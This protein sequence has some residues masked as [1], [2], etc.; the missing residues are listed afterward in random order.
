MCF[1][2]LYV[3]CNC[4]KF[5]H[6]SK[7]VTAFREGGLFAPLKSEVSVIHVLPENKVKRFSCKK[8]L[9]IK[10]QRRKLT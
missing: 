6:C 1:F 5:H 9:E 4:A 2:D 7:C 10:R 8:A 3:R